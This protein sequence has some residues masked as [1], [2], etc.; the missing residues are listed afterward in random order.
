VLVV[1]VNA[2]EEPGPRS[3]LWKQQVSSKRRHV[4]FSL[5]AFVS[6]IQTP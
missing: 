3:W 6:Q 2:S 1:L 5:H 4:P